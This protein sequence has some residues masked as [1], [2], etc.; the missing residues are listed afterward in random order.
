LISGVLSFDDHV[1]HDDV[2]DLR[3]NDHRHFSCGVLL[4]IVIGVL[5]F[6]DHVSHG[7]LRVLRVNDLILVSV[8]GHRGFSRVVSFR[9]LLAL[10]RYLSAVVNF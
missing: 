7:D 1:S 6:D 10:L 9:V 3:V 2:H 8:R 4:V 5:S